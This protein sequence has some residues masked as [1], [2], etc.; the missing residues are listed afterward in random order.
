MKRQIGFAEAESAGK[1]R[2]TKRQRFLAYQMKFWNAQNQKYGVRCRVFGGSTAAWAGKVAPF[3]ATDFAEREW[4][5]HSGWPLTI[6][7]LA[8]YVTRAAKRL[9]L[10]PLLSDRQFWSNS[11]SKMPSEIGRLKWFS[12]FFWH[13][14]RSPNDMTDVTR[15]GPDFQREDHEDVTAICNATVRSIKSGIDRVEGVEIISSLSGK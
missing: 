15:F 2:V 14:A 8:P 7:A 12:S 1:K 3:D 11:K 6:E 5:S 4:V 9:D 10:G 13:I